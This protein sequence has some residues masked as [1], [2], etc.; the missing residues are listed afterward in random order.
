MT[1]RHDAAN[2][3]KRDDRKGD[4]QQ[5]KIDQVHGVSSIPMHAV[6]QASAG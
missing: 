2:R 6:T 4:K 1:S 3:H 5:G